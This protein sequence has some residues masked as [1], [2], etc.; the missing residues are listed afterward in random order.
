[1]FDVIH[2]PSGHKRR[3]T[4]IDYGRRVLHFSQVIK[5]NGET[6]YWASLCD[7]LPIVDAHLCA[8]CMQPRL[9]V[10]EPR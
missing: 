10:K 4:G 7:C 3:V 9:G 8:E 1:M 6:F 5:T 2:L